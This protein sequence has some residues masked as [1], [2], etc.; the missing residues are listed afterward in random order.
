MCVYVKA[1]VNH[2][3]SIFA[4]PQFYNNFWRFGTNATGMRE[5]ERGGGRVWT[6]DAISVGVG[7]KHMGTGICEHPTF[8]RKTSLHSQ[9]QKTHTN[10]Y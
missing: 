10:I 4:P 2:D 6:G 9:S 7:G 8:G 3:I 5:D 1:V